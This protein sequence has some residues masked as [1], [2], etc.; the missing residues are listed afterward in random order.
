M[1]NNKDLD[2]N[3]E[4]GKINE[5]T[6]SLEDRSDSEADEHLPDFLNNGKNGNKNAFDEIVFEVDGE[7]LVQ[8]VQTPYLFITFK[9]YADRS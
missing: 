2:F 8:N 9:P 4:L 5:R 6:D 7:T 3:H 1:I